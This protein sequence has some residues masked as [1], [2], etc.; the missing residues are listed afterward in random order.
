[1]TKAKKT[2]FLNEITNTPRSK[3]IAVDRSSKTLHEDSDHHELHQEAPVQFEAHL[4]D[5]E[6]CNRIKTPDD[7][8]S[9]DIGDYSGISEYS[10][11]D[12]VEVFKENSDYFELFEDLDLEAELKKL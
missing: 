11:Y 4:D 7:E 12:D 8:P 2:A 1:M 3:K 6:S 5:P 10:N 9:L